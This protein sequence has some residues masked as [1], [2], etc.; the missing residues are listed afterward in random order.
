MSQLRTFHD[1]HGAEYETHGDRSVV[2][3]YGRA[4]R[5][6]LAV[7]NGVGVI[8]QPFDVV[9]VTGDDRIEYVDNVVSNAIATSEGHGAYAFLLDPHG[10]I[11]LDMYVYTAADRLL[12]FLPPGT[13]EE[14][15][16]EW[17]ERIFIQ[18]VSLEIATEAYTI[19]TITGPQATEKLASVSNVTIPEDMFAFVQA[20]LGD[21]GVTIIPTDGL[22]GEETYDIV[23]AAYDAE[24]VL[25]TLV[26]RGL[27]A[28]PFGR[29]TW[30]TLTLEAGTPLFDTE[31]RDALP[32]VTG[33][34]F[35]LDFEK[36][37]FVG[38]EIVSRIENRGSPNERIVGLTSSEILPHSAIV[39]RDGERIGRVTR[40]VMSPT[41]DRAIALAYVPYD[42]SDETVTIGDDERATIEPLPFIEGSALSARLPLYPS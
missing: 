23:C 33:V 40:S 36:G 13:A 37:C 10:R 5:T 19:L 1:A 34:R 22:T 6:H 18:D 25:D 11:R 24:I 9:I 17:R 31:L 7:R 21:A 39:N 16:A 14:L 29:Q 27:N 15:V 30:E 42:F 8:E 38:Q 41:L 28:V 32:N 35:G 2:S 12:I 4:E 20:S 26:N 3:T